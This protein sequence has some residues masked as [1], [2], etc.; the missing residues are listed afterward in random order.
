[1]DA[2]PEINKQPD[3]VETSLN[4]EHY[5]RFELLKELIAAS[6]DIPNE[7]KVLFFQ[8]YTTIDDF[9]DGLTE[10]A[11]DGAF[12]QLLGVSYEDDD[13]GNSSS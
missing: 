4:R 5:E 7:R 13:E 12:S 8:S 11:L 9:I 10:A 6:P 1:M 2:T 3:R